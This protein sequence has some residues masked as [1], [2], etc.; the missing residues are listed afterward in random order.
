M[1]VFNTRAMLTLAYKNSKTMLAFLCATSLAVGLTACAT[2]RVP[3]VKA[4]FIDFNRAGCK[5]EYPR[6]A[7]RYEQQCNVEL[8]VMVDVDG[9]IAN[10]DI[11]KSSS[12]P[13]LDNAVRER[14]LAG[15]C[16]GTP[17]TVDGRAQVAHTKVRYVWRLE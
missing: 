9:S 1:P 16:K 12:F 4:P 6:A 15:L 3:V 2:N 14:L 10:V 17:G 7:L 5:P 13:L 11:M 8:L